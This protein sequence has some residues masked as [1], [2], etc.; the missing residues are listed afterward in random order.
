MKS[1]GDMT[2]EELRER[3][4]EVDR[5]LVELAG[6]RSDLVL[7]IGDRKSR[8]GLPVLDPGREAL[9]IRR[10]SEKARESGVDEEM[11]RDV[12]WRVIASAREAQ[13]RG[14]ERDPAG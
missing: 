1:H 14:R 13:S 4:L 10:A 2:L 6:E 12:L 7:A 9:V 3:V 11:V 8:M 5:K